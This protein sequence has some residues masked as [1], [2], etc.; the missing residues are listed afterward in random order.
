ML[1]FKILQMRVQ[2]PKEKIN[3][4][5]RLRNF[6]NAF[7]NLLVRRSESV[8]PSDESVLCADLWR[9]RKS[10]PQ[11]DFFGDEIDRAQP[12]RELL[13]KPAQHEKQRL[14]SLDLVFE[15]EALLERLRGLN[16]FKEPIRLT[17]GAFPQPDCFRPEPRAEL[18]LIERSELS[19]RVN[20]PLVQ[21]RQELLSLSSSIFCG[22]G[23]QRK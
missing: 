11:G 8:S 7:V 1:R 19:K 18:F 6:K 22:F 9:T 14:G 21:D 2:H 5:G 17:V 16:K 4:V 3:I 23:I 12:Q 20:A 13:Q 15:L 10:N